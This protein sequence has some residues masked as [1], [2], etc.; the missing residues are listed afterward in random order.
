MN[1]Q[2]IINDN[3]L[4]QLVG[5]LLQKYKEQLEE[6][7]IN[8]SGKLSNT[9]SY[10]I[11][12]EGDQIAIYFNLEDYWKYV[13]YGRHAGKMPPVDKIAEWIRVKKIV[14]RAKNGK[15]PTTQQ[16]AYAISTKIARVGTNG[17]HALWK[18]T[19]LNDSIID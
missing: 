9:A 16:L 6:K 13:E 1:E 14:P 18:A 8:A 2:L 10:S 17:R 4:K 5:Q 3:E 7:N 15:V 19:N 11:E 12:V